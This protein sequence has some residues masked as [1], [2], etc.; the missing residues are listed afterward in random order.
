MFTSPN[1]DLSNRFYS[2]E[3]DQ[4]PEK[5]AAIKAAFFFVQAFAERQKNVKEIEGYA[6][7]EKIDFPESK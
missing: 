5:R 3:F 7:I 4:N 6:R 1:F 2:I